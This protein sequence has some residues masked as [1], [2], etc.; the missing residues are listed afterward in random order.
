MRPIV[1]DVPWCVS[2]CPLDAAI[3]CANTD[4]PINMLFGA[5]TQ[6][7]PRNRFRGG[8]DLPERGQFWWH[9]SS[10]CKFVT[11][12]EYPARGRY[13]Q[14]YSVGGS[15]DAAFRCR[16]CNSLLYTIG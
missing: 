7:G 9:F 10:H 13:A 14:P 4:K 5:W 12:M 8:A 11:Y 2:M 1:S 15:I 3:S 16:Y 6:V